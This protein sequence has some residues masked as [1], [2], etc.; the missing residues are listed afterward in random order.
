MM[1][2]ASDDPIACKIYVVIRFIHAK[3]Q[4]MWKSVVNYKCAVYSLNL[5]SEGAIRMMQN[6]QR[7]ANEC[8]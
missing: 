7:W 1:C 4:S 5:M 8:S 6:V 3:M 2:P